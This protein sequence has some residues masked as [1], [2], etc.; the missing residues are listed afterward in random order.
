[1]KNFEYQ[2]AMGKAKTSAKRDG[3]PTGADLEAYLAEVDARTQLRIYDAM[4]AKPKARHINCDD[5][6]PFDWRG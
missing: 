6:D 5:F 1:M 3:P 4:E 2:R